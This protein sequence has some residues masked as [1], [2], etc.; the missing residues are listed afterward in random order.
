MEYDVSIIVPVYNAEEYLDRC[1]QSILK[2]TFSN[3]EL[4]LINDGSTDKSLDICDKYCRND[5]RIIVINQ[6]NKGVSF[7]RNLGIEIAKG[8]FLLFIDSDDCIDCDM[9]EYLYNMIVD[10]DCD[11]SMCRCKLY[12]DGKLKNKTKDDNV[13]TCYKTNREI[14][15]N[16]IVENKFLLSIWNKLYKKSIFIDNDIRFPVDIRYS[17]DAVLNYKVFLNINKAVFGNLQKY[18]YYINN[19]STVKN[20]NESRID[21]LNAMEDIYKI[22]NNK[23][24]EFR[25]IIA[26]NYIT[27]SIDIIIDIAKEKSILNK[28]NILKSIHLLSR[29]N[30]HIADASYNLNKK[31][32]RLYSIMEISPILVAVMYNINFAISGRD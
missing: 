29:K 27:S 17:E 6:E 18:N 9:I 16:F 22:V 11:V 4:I 28:Y 7:S 1:I 14:F 31:Y 32:S 2:Q 8:R 15:E 3:F 19:S 13:I 23:Y 30:R 21:I 24:P 10:Y 12:I 25:Y 26:N 20:L 5:R